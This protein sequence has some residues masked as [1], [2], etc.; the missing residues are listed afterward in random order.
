MAKQDN[1]LDKISKADKIR[2]TKSTYLLASRGR[3]L[4]WASSFP[5]YEITSH[6]TV[7]SVKILSYKQSGRFAIGIDNGEAFIGVQR[8]EQAWLKDMPLDSI[9]VDDMIYLSLSSTECINLKFQSFHIG[10]R[11][12]QSQILQ[13]IKKLD[14]VRFVEITVKEGRV[15]TV[16]KEFRDPVMLCASTIAQSIESSERERKSSAGLI[17]FM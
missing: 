1:P 7:N 5:A 17:S 9:T 8:L 13:Q 3:F 4:Q 10:I 12:N 15:H 14:Y 11:C 6:P 2:L 16:G